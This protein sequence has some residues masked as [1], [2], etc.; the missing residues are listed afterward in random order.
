M[1]KITSGAILEKEI[2][3]HKILGHGTRYH[4]QYFKETGW[5]TDFSCREHI[6]PHG[7]RHEHGTRGT[8]PRLPL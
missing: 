1:A 2:G 8:K 6:I 3:A 7:M 5:F 4:H